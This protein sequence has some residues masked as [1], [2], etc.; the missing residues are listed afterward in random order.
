[1]LRSVI[2]LAR[3]LRH[4]TITMNIV[5]KETRTLEFNLGHR[6]DHFASSARINL[7][8]LRR[9]ATFFLEMKSNFSWDVYSK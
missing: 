1:M 4:K 3:P 5:V 6:H 8:L 2:E 9:A 7:V